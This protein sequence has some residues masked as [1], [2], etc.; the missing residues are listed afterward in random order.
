MNDSRRFPDKTPELEVR[1]FNL[2]AIKCYTKA[3]FQIIDRYTKDTM[4]GTDTFL[5]MRYSNTKG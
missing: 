2:R 5:L 4:T 1:E 3:G